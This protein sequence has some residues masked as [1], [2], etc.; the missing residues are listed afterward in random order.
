MGNNTLSL[1][2]GSETW[3]ETMAKQFKKMGHEVTVY[4]PSL[5]LIAIKLESDNIH[6]IDTLK[7]KN[8]MAPFDFTLKQELDQS[9]DVAICNHHDITMDIRKAFPNLP[10]I[11][12]IHGIIQKGPNGEIFPEHP[13]LEANVQKFVSVSEEIQEI[14]RRDFNIESERIFNGIDL[15]RFSSH[16]RNKQPKVI[17]INSNYMTLE[18]PEFAIIKDIATYYGAE[19]RAIGSGFGVQG[20]YEI[21]SLLKDADIVFGMGRSLLEAIACGCLA[22]CHG[23]WGTGGIV[24]TNEQYDTISKFNFSGRNSGGVFASAEDL[25]KEIDKYYPSEFDYPLVPTQFHE[26][27]D[28]VK[29]AEKYIKIAETLV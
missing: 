13:A 15:E 25:I 9:F 16:V 3:T 24:Q 27:H 21:E 12:T 7:S 11:A 8:G 4:S 29:C 26:N 18:M 10:I 23:R 14:L 1:L 2:A 5:G 19:L 6:C 17:L 20:T 22:I 28:I